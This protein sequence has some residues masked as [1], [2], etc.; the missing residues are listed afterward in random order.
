MQ[1]IIAI[2]MLL[3]APIAVGYTAGELVEKNIQAKGGIEKLRAIQTLRLSG[4]IV[5]NG[6]LLQ[7]DYVTLIKRPQLVRYE[8]KLQGLTQVQAYDGLQ[9]WQINPFQGR[10]DPEKLS[11]D[12]AKGMSEDAADVVGALVDYQQK[13]YRLESLGTEDVDG[14]DAYKLRVTRPN[15]DLIYVYLDPDYFLEIRT[16]SRRIEHG[17]ANETITDYGDYEEVNGVFLALAQE[18]GQKGSS[19]RQ[20]VQFE[21]AEVNVA[22]DDAPF[23]FPA[24]GGHAGLGQ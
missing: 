13:N 12:D 21:T 16:L 2:V 3:A 19:E 20:K 10:K 15:G 14:T 4:K 18:S 8:A 5:V 9:A 17:V 11:A 6:G 1:A 7:L 24:I 23:H 22:V